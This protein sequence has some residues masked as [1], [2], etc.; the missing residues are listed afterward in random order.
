M[1]MNEIIQRRRRFRGQRNQNMCPAQQEQWDLRQVPVL[2]K[3]SP[4]RF[5][6]GWKV[7]QG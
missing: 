2:G 3:G 6:E 7:E 4:I 5:L 1:L